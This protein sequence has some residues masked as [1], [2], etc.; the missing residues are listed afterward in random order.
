MNFLD[1]LALIAS[2]KKRHSFFFFVDDNV[3]LLTMKNFFFSEL[4]LSEN[5]FIFAFISIYI[6]KHDN[7]EK[8]FSH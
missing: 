8:M 3:N 2:G 4:D 1:I 5:S 7:L 6:S